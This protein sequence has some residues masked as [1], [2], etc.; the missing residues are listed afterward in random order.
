MRKYMV[1][2]MATGWIGIGFA[3]GTTPD[4]Q[5]AQY[6]AQGRAYLSYDFGGPRRSNDA[7]MP[8]H[9]GFRVDSESRLADERYTG[10]TDRQMPAMLQ[11][12]FAADGTRIAR[13][14]GIPFAGRSYILRQN[15]GSP[16]S[17]APA[18]A[19]GEPGG[20]TWFDWGLLAVGVGGLGYIIAEVSKGKDS[21]D[22][23]AAAS[24]TTTAGGTVVGTVTGVVTG[25]VNAV[26]GAVTNTTAVT[27]TVT[28]VL[29]TVTGVL[30][31]TTGFTS[32]RTIDG[33][34]P[35][36]PVDHNDP[37]YQKWL[38]GGN[39]QMGDLGG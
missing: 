29:N 5:F 27:G 13:L 3:A 14:N 10:L 28:G 6:S 34:L 36:D 32:S 21:P 22:P 24:G 12:D 20:F 19:T 2:A 37:A 17:G 7:A 26:T 15:D 25:V 33:V 11:L 38:D 30:T 31:G 4:E 16:D 23:P 39:G 9:Y 8:L 1:A 35:F 18:A